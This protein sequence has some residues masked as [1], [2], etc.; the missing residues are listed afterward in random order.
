MK[1]VAIFSPHVQRRMAA[2]HLNIILDAFARDLENAGYLRCNIQKQ[3][4]IAEH[5]GRWLGQRRLQPRQITREVIDRFVRLHLPQC[6]CPEPAPTTAQR[7]R[8]ALNRLL[9]LLRRRGLVGQRP[10]PLTPLD[11]LV[12]RFDNYLMHLLGLAGASRRVYCRF[13]HQF[14]QW[15]FGKLSPRPEQIRRSDL[16]RFVE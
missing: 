8:A 14:L 3:I 10:D 12:G 6:H 16:V 5:F 9:E 11:R 2:N 4:R 13:G 7:C 15:R 1:R